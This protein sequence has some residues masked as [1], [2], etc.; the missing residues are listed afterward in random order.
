M[1][2]FITGGSGYVGAML[3]DQYASRSDVE[4]ILLIDKEPFSD[5]LEEHPD[6]SKI[7][8][9]QGNLGDSDWQEKVRVFA[10]DV[11]IHTAWQI[12]EMYGQKDV[13]WKWNVTGSD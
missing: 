7:S 9:I 6:K 12:R 3:A 8:F 10:P 4:A 13:Q 11:I 2:L 1:K 5:L